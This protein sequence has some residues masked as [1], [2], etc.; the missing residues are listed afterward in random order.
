MSNFYLIP[1]EKTLLPLLLFAATCNGFRSSFLV[2]IDRDVR[3][4]TPTRKAAG[5]RFV[6]FRFPPALVCDVFE[7]RKELQMLLVLLGKNNKK[8][9]NRVQLF[10]D[11]HVYRM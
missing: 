7:N 1:L 10:V 2:A 3:I 8:L 4:F 11:T 5:G 9:V 6:P